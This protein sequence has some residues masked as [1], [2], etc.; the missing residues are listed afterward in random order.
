MPFTLAHPIA[1]LPLWWG[2]QRR[3]DLTALMIGATIP[4]ISYFIALQ[5]V[6]NIGHQFSGIFL[7]GIPSAF[8]LL[9]IGKYVLWQPVMQLLP[10]AI[11][12]RF[13]RRC[14]YRIL[15]VSRLLMITLSIALGAATHIVWDN[16]THYRGWGV[17]RIG[18]LSHE[19]LNLPIY[20]WLQH[21][22]GLIGFALILLFAYQAFRTLESRYQHSTSSLKT[23]PISWKVFAGGAISSIT[24][25][26][27]FTAL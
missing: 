17:N 3:L 7:E 18:L 14:P 11:A 4:D 2:S 19:V 9:L 15:P 10:R 8:A 22:G 24:I 12:Q 27:I 20:K 6:A 25:L 16:F 13:P 23:L 21:S 1:A 26:T 5:P